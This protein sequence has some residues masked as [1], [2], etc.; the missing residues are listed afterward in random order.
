[1]GES[2]E[3]KEILPQG[4]NARN[5]VQ[6]PMENTQG[7]MRPCGGQRAGDLERL[8]GGAEYCAKSS[9]HAGT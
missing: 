9:L 4:G 8:R 5:C 6:L 7:C 1:M 2:L 3:Q